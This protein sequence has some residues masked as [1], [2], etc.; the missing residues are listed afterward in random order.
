MEIT[1]N[2]KKRSV[3]DGARLWDARDR[4]SPGAGVVIL[5]GFQTD[6]NLPLCENDAVTL[7]KKGE[8]PDEAA[9][10]HMLAARLSPGV[11]EKLAGAC[12]GV[13]GLGGVG[14]AVAMLLARSGVGR[15]VLA[16]FDVV[17][18]SNLN[19]QH[20]FLRHL[21]MAKAAALRGEI[22]QAN[23]YVSVTA[24]QIKLTEENSPGFFAGCQVVCEA[25][26]GAAQKAMLARALLRADPNQKVVATSGMAGLESANAIKSRR[27]FSNLYVCGD[28]TA[29][30]G[31][32]QGLFAPR[33]SVCA[34]H[35]ANAVLRLLLGFQD[36]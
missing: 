11:Y 7:I 35:A 10:S 4:F 34:G 32:H 8:Y 25:F 29:E 14:S 18:P 26:D 1:V 20:Y 31:F 21:G 33:V 15:L 13:A 9:L 17:E 16:D 23:P 12:V 30:A 28:E 24:A 19:R 22:L 2:G 6:E 27:A 36:V 3:P 5:N